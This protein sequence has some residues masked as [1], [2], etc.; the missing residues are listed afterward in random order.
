MNIV[1]VDVL[2]I[3]DAGQPGFAEFTL[4]D[5]RGVQHHFID[6]LP[7]VCGSYDAVPPCAGEIGC[8]IVGETADT[9]IIDTEE[10]WDIDS[11]DGAYQF[12]VYKNMVSER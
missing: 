5:C 11:L 9:F 4:T 7:V 12:E 10:P 2:R 8:R 6:K 3:T 1:K